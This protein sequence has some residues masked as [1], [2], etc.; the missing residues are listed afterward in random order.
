[1][2]AY[3]DTSSIVPLLVDEPGT[4]AARA[5]WYGADRVVSVRLSYVE[6]RS[7]LAQALRVG[8]LTT[9][10]GRSARAGLEALLDQIDYVEVDDLLVREAA[11]LADARALRAYDA[12]HLAAALAVREPELVFVAGDK[13]LVAAAASEGLMTAPT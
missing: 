11:K 9:D 5:H 6:T 4:E 10:H 1:M 7:A 3:F 2:I 13:A 8:T 12:V